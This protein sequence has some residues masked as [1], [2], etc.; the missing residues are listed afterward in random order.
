MIPV[1]SR[2][3]TIGRIGP[4]YAI[5][6]VRPIRE[7]SSLTKLPPGMIH[8]SLARVMEEPSREQR[9]DGR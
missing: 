1:I 9:R 5:E 7:E 4:I 2:I 8:G 3:R 6:P